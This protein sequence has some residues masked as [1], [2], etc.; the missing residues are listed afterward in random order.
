VSAQLELAERV[1]ALADG[2]AQ[3]TVTRERSLEVPFAGSA[4]AA[5]ADAD[6]LTVHVLALREGHTASAV[7]TSTDDTALSAAV[8]RATAAATLAAEQG[9]GDHPGLPAP[10]DAYRGH[11]GFDMATA[12]LDARQAAAQVRAASDAAPDLH[13][14]GLWSVREVRT[15]IASTA[16]VR[17][18]DAVTQAHA[19]VSTDGGYASAA[20]V[21]ARDLDL[22]ALAREAASAAPAGAPAEIDAGTHPV[23]LSEYAL[24][25]LLGLLG[26]MAFNGLAHADGRG[27]LAGRLGTR[28]AA[29][30]INLSD[31]PRFAGTLPRAFDAEGVPKSP[32]PLIQD[33]VAHRVV[34]DTRSA[35]R[36][37]AQSTG[38][39]LAPGGLP[40]GPAPSNLVLVGG[41]AADA[42]ELAKPI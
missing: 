9:A 26:V 14:S 31:S 8:R 5:P 38:H 15:A 37:G 7:T 23:V 1:L 27:A 17:A 4:L 19:K 28:V 3:V 25:Q 11:Q 42:A 35:A 20:A 40:E 6:V 33:G 13:L 41:G 24:G 32:V 36:A 39:A 2:D 16:G 10:P 30:S 18:T 34:H 29:A 12:Q 22:A 21:A